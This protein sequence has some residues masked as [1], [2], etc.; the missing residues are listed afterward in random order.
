LR[1]NL[2]SDADADILR[3]ILALAQQLSAPLETFT[4]AI[5]AIREGEFKIPGRCSPPPGNDRAPSMTRTL[6]VGDR[7]RWT[8]TATK[9]SDSDI[10]LRWPHGIL[11]LS[12]DEIDRIYSVTNDKAWLQ[13]YPVMAPESPLSQD[14]TQAGER[15]VEQGITT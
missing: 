2:V 12:Q 1:L 3:Q 6:N 11:V 10:V 14:Q 13:R 5:G 8:L 15:L 7:L 9:Q 4:A